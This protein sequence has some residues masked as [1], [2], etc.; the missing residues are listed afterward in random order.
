MDKQEY[1]TKKEQI[2]ES[3]A[4][5]KREKE[6]L[7]S[8]YIESNRVFNDGEKVL[9]RTK[10]HPYW[11]AGGSEPSGMV[12]EE[13]RYAFI[14]RYE[15]ICDDV[16]PVLSK[17]KKDGTMSKVRDCLTTRLITVEKLKSD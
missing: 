7:D 14:K 16:V 15:I 4:A 3:I 9:V 11:K 13:T 2:L 10:E 12:K 6:R 8:E 5:L 17:C 1:K